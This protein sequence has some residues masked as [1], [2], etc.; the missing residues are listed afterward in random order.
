[1]NSVNGMLKLDDR[2]I[3]RL[4][5]TKMGKIMQNPTAEV[6]QLYSN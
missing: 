2:I 3:Q 1:M 4:A 6:V 5:Y